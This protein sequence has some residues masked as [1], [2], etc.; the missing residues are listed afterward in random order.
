[1]KKVLDACVII[2]LCNIGMFEQVI[3]AYR[4]DDELYVSKSAFYEVSREPSRSMLESAVRNGSIRIFEYSEAERREVYFQM[5]KN[6]I[7]IHYDDV[8]N[9]VA[10][11][12]LDAELI[13]DDHVLFTAFH[14]WR[15]IQNKK[16][17]VMNT[18]GL[19]FELFLT[20]RIGLYP[21]IRGLLDL[22]RVS[23]LPNMLYQIGRGE[24]GVE[25][26]KSLF[27]EYEGYMLRSISITNLDGGGD[28]WKK[29]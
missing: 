23:E 4:Q 24:I 28:G 2:R 6:G 14:K 25:D 15:D 27:G 11:I 21:F 29:Q 8:P 9:A 10:A 1:M 19:M 12:E 17:F 26:A 13:T 7:L 22:F 18:R 20:D 3:G 16:V 5:K